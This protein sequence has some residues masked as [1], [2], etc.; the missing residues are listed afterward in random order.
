MKKNKTMKLITIVLTLILFS[1]GILFSFSPQVGKILFPNKTKKLIDYNVSGID[2][3]NHQGKID[4]KAVSQDNVK[5]CF[6]KA[7]EGVTF[8][9]KSFKYNLQEA[10]KNGV[11]VGA[12]HY[13]RFNKNINLQFKNYITSVDKNS[14]YFPPVVDVEF[15]GNNALKNASNKKKF[16]SDLKSLLS[17]LEK[18]YGMRPIVYTDHGFYHKLLVGELDYPFWMSDLRGQG[19]PYLDSTQWNFWQHSFMGRKKGIKSYVDINVFN[20]D[21]EEL[22]NLKFNTR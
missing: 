14:I 21:L 5:F 2:V 8:K 22:K 10:K 20:G 11:L 7:T 12:Y 1:C 15:Y 9:D 18:H 16:V 13:F 19:L 3:S 4:W 17:L 6:I